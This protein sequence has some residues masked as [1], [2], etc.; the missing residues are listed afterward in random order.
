[1]S[2]P[3]PLCGLRVLDLSRLLP[4][5]YA[6]LVLA[7]LGADVVKVEDPHGGDYLR[8]MPP[9]VDGTSALFLALNRGK[10]SVTLDLKRDADREL[11][12]SLAA[13]ADVVIESFR[14]GVLDR[15]GVGF[16][17]LQEANPGIVLCSISGFGQDGPY[18]E[19]AG[20]DL[21]YLAIGGVLSLLGAKDG[22]PAHPNVQVADVAGG[23]M[24]GLLGILA[25]LVERGRTGKGRWV[26]ASM[27]EGAMATLAL[28]VAPWL[29]GAGPVPRRGEGVLSGE[30]P[31]YGLY[32]TADGRHLAVGALEPKFWEGF[33]AAMGRPDLAAHGLDSGEAGL[34]VR[35][36]V[37]RVVAARPL[38]E[39]QRV[40]E[41]HD[42]CVE[43][44][45]HAEEL[46]DHPQ[47][48]ARG[49]FFTGPHGTALRTP[50][51][52]ADGDVPPAGTP[53]PPP[54]GDPRALLEEWTVRA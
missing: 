44:V 2:R 36:E 38:A 4:G 49:S 53:A 23:A 41:S 17:R 52:F 9:L 39:W 32:E 34:R 15:L 37:A 45:L 35:E 13:R 7:D 47:H 14:P 50:V 51:R 25:A 16:A 33:C 21:G 42:V 20:H 40:L 6:S 27:T 18:R 8:W 54:G 12:L 48:R 19:R 22:P 1:M 5:P 28:T 11:F 46:P 3:G 29:A 10:R 30:M 43:A 26:D 31:C 24:N